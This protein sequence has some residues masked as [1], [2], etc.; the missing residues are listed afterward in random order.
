MLSIPTTTNV[1]G[2]RRMESIPVTLLLPSR[3][4]SLP[5]GDAAQLPRSKHRACITWLAATGRRKQQRCCRYP[6]AHLGTEYVMY[7]CTAWHGS[8]HVSPS[9]EKD[10]LVGGEARQMPPSAQT[11]ISPERSPGGVPRGNIGMQPSVSGSFGREPGWRE[12][13][14]ACQARKELVHEGC[15]CPFFLSFVRVASILDSTRIIPSFIPSIYLVWVAGPHSHS[16][17]HHISP[18]L[19]AMCI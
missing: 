15:P 19:R 18:L 10:E 16:H 2:G 5:L 17:H 4:T 12:A 1:S 11:C 14:Q 13:G 7:V 6:S 9:V 8:P 3:H